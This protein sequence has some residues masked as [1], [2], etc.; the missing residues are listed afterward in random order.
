MLILIICWVEN[1]KRLALLVSLVLRNHCPH[2]GTFSG[3][4][5]RL[6]L[7]GKGF[8]SMQQYGKGDQLIN[9]NVWTPKNLTAE[10]TQLLE[11]MRTLSNFNP[12]PGDGEKGFFDRMKEYFN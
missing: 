7:K 8:P 2:A 6:Q 3:L 1:G 10:E 11:K 5:D 12:K 9:V 4:S